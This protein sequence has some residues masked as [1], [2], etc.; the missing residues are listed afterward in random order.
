MKNSTKKFIFLL[1]YFSSP[2]IV[3]FLFYALKPSELTYPP[4]RQLADILGITAYIFLVYEFILTSRLKI[5]DKIFGMDRIIL[6]HIIISDIALQLAIVHAIIMFYLSEKTAILIGSGINLLGQYIILMIIGAIF[7]HGSGKKIIKMKYNVAKTIHNFTII[8]TSFLFLHSIGTNSDYRSPVIVVIYTV[9][10]FFGLGAWLNLKIIRVRK[11]KNNPYDI[12]Q[13]KNE[14]GTYWTLKLQPKNGKIF[15]YTPGQYGYLSI[16]SQEISKEFHPFS[17]TSSPARKD[18]ISF[19]IKELG[20]YTNQIGTVKVGETAYIEGPYGIFNALSSK[21]HR[22]VLIAGGSGITPFLSLL[23][24]MKDTKNTRKVTL[25]WG[26]RFPYELFLNDE[27]EEMKRTNPSLT[28][29]PVVS[30]DE[31][32]EGESG[33]IDRERLE[34][35]APCVDPRKEIQ[36]NDYYICGPPAM[37]KVVRPALKLMGVNK[38]KYLHTEKFYR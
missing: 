20:D 10:Y 9:F 3:I 7:L 25:I 38:S 16:N 2:L 21:A 18:V 4:L 30:D 28:I 36:K 27:L 6:F 26:V 15:D 32:W 37:I 31:S 19:I 13:V 1:I 35:L 34:R 33:F 11:V 22:L 12:I 8:T 5:I 29:I 14:A 23:R 24:Y 17:F